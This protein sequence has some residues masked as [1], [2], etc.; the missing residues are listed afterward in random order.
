MTPPRP[1]EP[2]STVDQIREIDDALET[3]LASLGPE[4][5]LRP[6]VKD[7]RVRDV[8]AHLLD[9]NLRRL[10][11]DR[12]RHQ[13]R[14]VA[15]PSD[16]ESFRSWV[17]FLDSLNAQWT[18]AAQRLSSEVILSLLRATNPQVSDHFDS[19][20]PEAPATF[21]V[22][23]ASKVESRVWLDV[24][25]EYTEK[26]HHQQQIREAVDQPLLTAPH[27]VI[28]LIEILLRALPTAY[29]GVEAGE[30]TSVLI[31]AS[32][33]DEGRWL[34][35][36]DREAWALYRPGDLGAPN[37]SLALP[38]ETLWRT[39][40]KQVPRDEARSR[41]RM[42]GTAELVAPFFEAV[43]VMA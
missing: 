35:R 34:L 8:A 10:S 42:S 16:P 32:D 38:S 17:E 12:D 25:R 29:D 3:L 14:G 40:M 15:P 7:W 9:T 18:A 26:W 21:G 6:A 31:T 19:L 28:P 30:G 36:R 23:W 13:P 41:A 20:D 11:L 2:R 1:L 4:E 43:A 37:A 24:G 33:L 39:L 22:H 27:L 5:W